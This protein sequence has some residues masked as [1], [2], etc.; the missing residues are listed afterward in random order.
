MNLDTLG[1]EDA[2]RA[3][4]KQKTIKNIAVELHH[5]KAN[6]ESRSNNAT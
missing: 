1:I 2:R 4:I 3:C 6:F 5:G